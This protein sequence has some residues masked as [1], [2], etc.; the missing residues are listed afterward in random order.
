[1][2]VHVIAGSILSLYL[3]PLLPIIIGVPSKLPGYFLGRFGEPSTSYSV[4]ET[5]A[6]RMY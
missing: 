4:L 5:R 6:I 1:M 3:A 2:M